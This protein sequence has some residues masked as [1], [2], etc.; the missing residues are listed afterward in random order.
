[1]ACCLLA[2]SLP[3]SWNRDIYPAVRGHWRDGTT[4]ARNCTPLKL[5]VAASIVVSYYHPVFMHI[6]CNH[7]QSAPQDRFA[8]GTRKE[9]VAA[10]GCTG[11][12]LPITPAQQSYL[13]GEVAKLATGMLLHQVM[14]CAQLAEVYF[15]L[16]SCNVV[17]VNGGGV[18]VDGIGQLLRCRPTIVT[19]VPARSA[20]LSCYVQGLL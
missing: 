2:P 13:H 19:V 18:L 3:K 8:V 4:A 5:L 11:S 15:E 6:E 17:F 9:S 7:G 12:E 14:C 10:S 20:A 1:M 16:I